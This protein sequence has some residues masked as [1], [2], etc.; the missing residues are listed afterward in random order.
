MA[1]KYK[2]TTTVIIP[3]YNRDRFLPESIASLLRQTVVPDQILIVDDGS[4]DKTAEVAA[5]F[6]AQVEYHRKENGGKS[7]AL[8]FALRHCTGDFVWIFDDDDVAHPTALERFL[9]ALDG[10]P[11]ADFA[12]GEY[13][14][15]KN[16]ADIES[17]DYE[18]IKFDGI[19]RDTFFTGHLEYCHV[20]QPG[21]LVRR[22]C[23]DQVGGFNEAMVRSQDYE[24]M[25]RL[26]RRFEGVKVDGIVFYQRQHDMVRGNT[27]VVI[28]YANRTKAWNSYDR[29]IMED[30]YKSLDL[31]E[32][33][34]RSEQTLPRTVDLEMQALL[35]RSSV[36]A[37]K[38]L[39]HHA[40]SDIL[41]F[42]SIAERAGKV[43]LNDKE[44]AIVR[45]T[46]EVYDTGLTSPAAGEFISAIKK[47]KSGALKAELLREYMH[48]FPHYLA[49][50]LKVGK[51]VPASKLVHEYSMLSFSASIRRL[52]G[53][54]TSKLPS[55]RNA[56][57]Q[58][59]NR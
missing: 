28:S 4:T 54:M 10:E 23:Y 27:K 33:L 17:Q 56:D 37:R 5:S 59:A 20:H 16:S 12:Y 3:T 58:G 51:I 13:A 35:K 43:A 34:D 26:A 41:R 42:A 45:R 15:F 14:R 19:D 36:M 25:L 22:E 46:F 50:D 2:P 49:R 47:W 32:Y 18:L 57:A 40:A 7:T 9:T 38:G 21:L 11:T 8:N 52:G 30:V 6:G 53:A 1:M 44:R 39:W 24:M 55:L 48:S 31:H 29:L